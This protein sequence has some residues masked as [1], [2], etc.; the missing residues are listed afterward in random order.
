M[1]QH[2]LFDLDNTLYPAAM[3]MEKGITER[4]VRFVADFLGVGV[5]EARAIRKAKSGRS[6]TT[7]EW[8]MT[9]YNF[10]D[11]ERFFEAVHPESETGELVFDPRL[12]DFLI[13]LELPMSVL[14][15]APRVHADRVLSFYN[16]ADIFVTVVDIEKNN[17]KGKPYKSAFETAL[18]A[19]GFSVE[20]TLFFDDFPS[21]VAGFE[22]LGGKTVLVG[23][24]PAPSAPNRFSIQSIYETPRVLQE[25]NAEA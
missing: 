13:S 24:N 16:I 8:L 5:E 1:I 7:L 14:T 21:Y 2:L 3:P 20:E 4:M 6:S 23:E 15:N 9:E 12:R 11:A 10:G 22:A 18:N 17:L 19:A 25:M